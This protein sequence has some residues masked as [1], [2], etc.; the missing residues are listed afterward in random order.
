MGPGLKSFQGR[1]G[2]KE[3]AARLL[4]VRPPDKVRQPIRRV[5]RRRL[6]SKSSRPS[7]PADTR[8]PVTVFSSH[9]AP[10]H[11]SGAAPPA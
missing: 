10:E 4:Q 9:S 8:F 1:R 11:E 6:E 2:R 5:V 3:E 7:P